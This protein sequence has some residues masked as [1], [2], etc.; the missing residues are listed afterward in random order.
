MSQP[1]ELIPLLCARCQAPIPANPEEVAWVCEQCGQGLLLSEEK[2]TVPLTINFNKSLTQGSKGRPF[3]V[4]SGQVTLQRRIYGGNDQGR[5]AQE[6]WNQPRRFFVP[7]FDLPLDQMVDWGMRLLQ[8]PPALEP[9]SP[10]EFLAVT[11]LPGDAQQLAEFIVMG[12]EADRP[13]KIREI[14][15]SV[16]LDPPELWVI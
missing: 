7:A 5:Q 1:V 4:A 6:Y 2:G 10:T 16:K 8:Q 3:W 9:G 14:Q 11:L 12:V 13:D 15:L